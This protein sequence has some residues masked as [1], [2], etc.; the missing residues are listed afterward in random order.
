MDEE[1]ERPPLFGPFHRLASNTQTNEDAE[2]IE[3]SGELWGRPPRGSDVPQVQAYSG[4]LPEGRIGIEF[5]TWIAPTPNSPPGRERWH[6]LLTRGVWYD[7]DWARIR[8]RLTRNTHLRRR[9]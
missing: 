2:K 5:W 4:P 8:V 9:Q 3:A 7:E 6:P 1:P